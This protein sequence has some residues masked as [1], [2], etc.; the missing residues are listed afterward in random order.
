M[1]RWTLEI[2]TD[3]YKA[4]IAEGLK[5]F[6]GHIV[7]ANDYKCFDNSFHVDNI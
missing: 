5:Q 7:N 3:T 1:G 2:H 4:Y 6:R